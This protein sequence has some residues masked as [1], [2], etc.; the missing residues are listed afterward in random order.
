MDLTI[1][2]VDKRTMSYRIY[3]YE[4]VKQ[5]ENCIEMDNN[6][7]EFVATYKVENNDNASGSRN[8]F[9]QHWQAQAD[10]TYPA[11]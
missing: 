11:R 4:D 5:V 6:S 1:Q 9:N 10:R 8:E 3:E 7:I 2:A